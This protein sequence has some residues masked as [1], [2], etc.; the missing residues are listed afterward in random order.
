MDRG[1]YWVYSPWGQ[2]ELDIT[3]HAHMHALAYLSD[4]LS[5]S[6]FCFPIDSYFY[7]EETFP[8]FL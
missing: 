4:L 1:A 6:N 7:L 2:K 5:N 8:Y 3:E